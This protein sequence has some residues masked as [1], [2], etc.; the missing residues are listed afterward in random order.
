MKEHRRDIH[1]L[2]YFSSFVSVSGGK[3]IC[4]TEPKLAFCPLA[5]HLHEG[6]GRLASPD[7]ARV[8]KAVKRA[9]E[10]KIREH[11]FFTARRRFSGEEISVPYGASEMLMAALRNG[12]VDA[13][14]VVCDGA[15]TVIVDRA[16]AAQGIGGRMNTLLLTSPIREV[17]DRLEELGCVIVHGNALID[18]VG[19]AKAAIRRGHRTVAV[20]VAG[21]SSQDLKKLRLLEVEA[22]VR[23]I[24]LVVCTTG[25]DSAAIEDMRSYADLVWSCASSDVREKIGAE[26]LMQLSRLIPV[27]VL[28]RAGLDFVAAYADDPA[29]IRG[30]EEE[31]QYLVSADRKGRR[32]RMGHF[33]VV[34]SEAALP[35]PGRRMPVF[36]DRAARG[37]K[38]GA[39][40]H[41]RVS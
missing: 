25:V 33:G 4:V 26:A 2:K 40:Y 17:R 39:Y 23:I 1:V 30:L 6:L 28:T 35:V 8:K 38:A 5:A 3:V 27:F 20:T 22:G 31:R 41:E 9:I 32:L 34:L 16:E 37:L 13:A 7:P 12:A 24:S 14:V 29:L 10:S 15:G 19:G 21:H 11:G 36:R 18:Q